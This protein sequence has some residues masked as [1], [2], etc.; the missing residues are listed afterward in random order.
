MFRLKAKAVHFVYRGKAVPSGPSKTSLASAECPE[1]A[2]IAR[3]E[4]PPTLRQDLLSQFVPNCNLIL[5]KTIR[6]L[7]SLLKSQEQV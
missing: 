1:A 7:Y 4:K 3:K 6:N 2:S 5:P